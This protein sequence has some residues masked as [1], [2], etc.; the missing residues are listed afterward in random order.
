MEER[1]LYLLDLH[2]SFKSN[3]LDIRL[4]HFNILTNSLFI[5]TQSLFD[6]E[7]K[8]KYFHSEIENK[9]F[10]YGLANQS[11]SKLLKG[12]EFQLISLDVNITDLFSIFSITRM[13]IES[14][15]L[16]FYL[17][18]DN[19]ND[20][21][22]NFRYDIYKLHGLQKQSKF[23][24]TTENGN[25]KKK[26]IL[27]EIELIKVKI[28]KYEIYKNSGPKQ[29]IEF[30]KPKRAILQFSKELLLKSGLGTSRID[31]IWNLYSNHAHGEHISD[32]QFNYIYKNKKST[33]DESL[34]VITINS[35]ITAKLCKF[36]TNS[37]EGAE[38][39][40]NQLDSKSKVHIEIWNKLYE[41]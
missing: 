33:L 27:D 29:Q 18:Y 5:L 35:I 39:K 3:D 1:N 40:Y 41:K 12:N 38:K 23:D 25:K 30:L 14:Y 34:L 19:I 37:F 16:I 20:D 13:Q 22:K 9:Y 10:R 28:K 4:N 8:I 31:E 26:L 32:R 36:I 7:E 24:T 11:I 6:N 15:A 21:E 17:F 2:S